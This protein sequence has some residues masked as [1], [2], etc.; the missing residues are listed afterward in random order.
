MS[1]VFYR[2]LLREKWKNNCNITVL[3]WN[4]WCITKHNW[5]RIARYLP[6]L[7]PTELWRLLKG[8]CACVCVHSQDE[9]KGL[10]NN[11]LICTHFHTEFAEQGVL[12]GVWAL[13][14]RNGIPLRWMK[15]RTNKK[16]TGS[17]SHS[18]WLS[19][20]VSLE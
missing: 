13:W 4:T 19:N 11:A 5:Y 1:H 2:S 9:V 20:S 18:L 7:T 8:K 3:N 15:G 14:A 6:L 10:T 16:R 17:A 12:R